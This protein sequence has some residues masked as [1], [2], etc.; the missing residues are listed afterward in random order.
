MQSICKLI[1]VQ[2]LTAFLVLP[3]FSKPFF[4]VRL[5]A[6]FLNIQ[7]VIVFCCTYA[8]TKDSQQLKYSSYFFKSEHNP[9]T[10]QQAFN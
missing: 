2:L 9:P 6:V 10:F 3:C 5:A 8:L 1:L 7:H 4:V